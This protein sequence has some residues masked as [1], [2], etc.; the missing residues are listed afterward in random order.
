[1][2]A[3]LAAPSRQD[4]TTDGSELR[5]VCVDLQAE[6]AL[7]AKGTLQLEL[8]DDLQARNASLAVQI[9]SRFGRIYFRQSIPT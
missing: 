2:Y 9:I 6:S 1:M 5:P 3:L 7:L 4:G 8:K